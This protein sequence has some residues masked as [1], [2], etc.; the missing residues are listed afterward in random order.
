MS[1]TCIL[2]THWRL[3][4]SGDSVGTSKTT[5]QNTEDLRYLTELGCQKSNIKCPGTDLESQYMSSCM[6]GGA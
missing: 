4:Q 1:A 5:F 6:R 3:A 2:N